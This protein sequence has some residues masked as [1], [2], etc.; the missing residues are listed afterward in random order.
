MKRLLPIMLL[1]IANVAQGAPA[2]GCYSNVTSTAPD[3]RFT[4]NGDGTVT[5]SATRLMWKQCVEGLST[6]TTPCDTGTISSYLWQAALQ[7][8]D[9]INGSGGF[10]GYT[11]WRVPSQR[12]LQSLVERACYGPAI[13]ETY[14]PA[15]VAGWTLSSSPV[16][17]TPG[18]AW[19]VNF[20]DGNDGIGSMTN[21]GYL[22]LVRYR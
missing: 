14:F 1:A 10:A 16:A 9:T 15:V 11:D 20:V 21:D 3:S 13:N 7:Q 18:S 6:T 5:D 19:Y 12:E 22:R 4:D 8:V 17:G 2:S